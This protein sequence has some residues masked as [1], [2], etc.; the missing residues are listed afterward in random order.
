MVKTSFSLIHN[1]LLKSV[2]FRNL[3]SIRIVISK[4]SLI[5]NECGALCLYVLS[6]IKR[7]CVGGKFLIEQAGVSTIAINNHRE[8]ILW[9]VCDLWK[10]LFLINYKLYFDTLTNDWK[11]QSE[12]RN[13]R[14]KIWL[15]TP[16]SN[17]CDVKRSRR[18]RF[19]RLFRKNVT[20]CYSLFLK[21]RCLTF[22]WAWW[23]IRY[24]LCIPVRRFIF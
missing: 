6:H 14:L 20:T 22:E 10:L 24:L 23:V 21:M 13:S 1:T 3:L 11:L 17:S 12:N 5:I 19:A 15:D 16:S 4:S 7:T 18:I 2:V 9:L 8:L